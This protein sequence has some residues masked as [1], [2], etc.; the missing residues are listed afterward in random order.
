MPPRLAQ[1]GRPAT[2]SGV[3]RGSRGSSVSL[4]CLSGIMAQF[5]S[6]LGLVG[7]AAF[8]RGYFRTSY[9]QNAKFRSTRCSSRFS[10]LAA[11]LDPLAAIE[12]E[13]SAL[14]RTS[15]RGF[16]FW[17][18]PRPGRRGLGQS[19]FDLRRCPELEQS[20]PTLLPPSTD[21]KPAFNAGIGPSGCGARF[22]GRNLSAS[23]GSR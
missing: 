13:V 2:S 21:G 9:R 5:R 15:I 1:E 19:N 22:R 11:G 4:A 14:F 8:A 20:R 18:V 3:G 7:L 12:G 6:S 17:V 23:I 10:T 16:V